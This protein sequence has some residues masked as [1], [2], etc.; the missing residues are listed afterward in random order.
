MERNA[1]DARSPTISRSSAEV[2]HGRGHRIEEVVVG[3]HIKTCMKLTRKMIHLQCIH[4]AIDVRTVHFTTNVKYT[5]NANIAFDEVSSDR[6]LEHI[7]TDVTVSDKI[8]NKTTVHVKLDT[9]AS[10]NLLPYNVFKEIFPHVSVK[11][12]HHSIDNNVCLEAYNKSSIKQL[13]TC[14]L[15]VQHGRQLYLCHFFV[16]PDYCHPILGLNDIHALNL[17]SIHCH[18]TDKWSSG[19]LSPMSLYPHGKDE[20]FFFSV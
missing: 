16:V 13:G 8:G 6:K 14:H 15:T 3:K 9:G 20:S 10:G 1:S 17:I 2:T 12:L 18:V 7:L 19:N 11:E 5:H 4:D